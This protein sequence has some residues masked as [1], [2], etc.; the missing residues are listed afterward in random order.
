MKNRFKLTVIIIFSGFICSFYALE[1]CDGLFPSET[2]PTIPSDHSDN[3]SGAF[4]KPEPANVEDCKECHG[5]DLKGGIAELEGVR[6][7]A[8]S[9]YQ[10]HGDIWTNR[11]GGGGNLIKNK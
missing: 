8:N 5:N 10:C 1:G 11:G 9:C 4:H 7:Y 6:V 3:I 2:K